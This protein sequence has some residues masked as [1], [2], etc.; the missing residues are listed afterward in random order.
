[1]GSCE[2]LAIKFELIWIQVGEALAGVMIVYSC[3]CQVEFDGM[4]CFRET[5]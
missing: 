3:T 2:F 5:E 1:M 4:D